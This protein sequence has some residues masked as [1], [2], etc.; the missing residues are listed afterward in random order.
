M[1]IRKI[2]TTFIV[3]TGLVILSFAVFALA[4]ESSTADK[5][6]FLDSDQDGL[7]NTEEKAYGTDPYKADTDGDGYSDGVEVKSGYDPLKPA[8]G[9]KIV[10]EAADSG[11]VAGTSTEKTGDQGKNLTTDV[12]QQ[13]S[14]LLDKSQSEN[15][16]VTTEDLDTIVSQITGP[17]LDF[18]DLPQ[19]DK[20]T[21]KIKKQDYSKLSEADK[22]AKEKD[23]DL[24]YLSAV[25]YILINN[26]PY[27]ISKKDD[28]TKLSQ[29]I[30]SQVQ[31]FSSTFDPSYFKD[32]ATKGEASLKQMNDLEVPENLVDT[33]IQGLQLANYAITLKDEAKIDSS[34]PALSMVNLSK[35][36]NLMN[37]SQKFMQDT[38]DK[39][40][41]IGISDLPINLQ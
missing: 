19:I 22:A 27:Q 16:A 33:H 6:I 23:D 37:L 8:P 9:D 18:S 20:K 30:I 39:L 12:S 7:T 31:S 29:D 28:L 1:E 5:N 21:I 13:V 25:S 14:A 32:L 2:K 26:S 17:T 24:Q 3:F 41:K 11:T 40:Q 36:E 38:Q 4:Q 34:D 10:S 35:V 15:K